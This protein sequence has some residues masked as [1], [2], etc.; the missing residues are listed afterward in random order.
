MDAWHSQ[1]PDQ[2]AEVEMEHGAQAPH[3]AERSA[4]AG[5]PLPFLSRPLLMI[6]AA[7]C[8]K[9]KAIFGDRWESTIVLAPLGR[10][11]NLSTA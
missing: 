8:G 3:P 5:P 1:L 7:D 6:G 2:Q 9:V 4:Q 11:L 10:A